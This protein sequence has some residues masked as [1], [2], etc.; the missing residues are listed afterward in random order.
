MHFFFSILKPSLNLGKTKI[1]RLTT[2][3]ILNWICWI[4]FFRNIYLELSYLRNV[5]DLKWLYMFDAPP[6]TWTGL[7]QIWPKNIV[8]LMLGRFQVKLPNKAFRTPAAPILLSWSFEPPCKAG[9][10]PA[11]SRL[12]TVSTRLQAHQWNHLQ[13][14][15]P[16][17]GGIPLN[18]PSQHY[19]EQKNHLVKACLNSLTNSNVSIIKWLFF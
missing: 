17:A 1:K 2:K 7:W 6:Q 13:H 10:G 18:D 11:E 5:P 12:T 19:V 15:V 4:V 3:K 16:A 14:T 9:G 8:E